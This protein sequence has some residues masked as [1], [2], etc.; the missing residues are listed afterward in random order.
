MQRLSLATSQ[1]QTDASSVPKQQLPWKNYPQF[2]LLSMVPYG[3]E[4]T[5]GQQG[6]AVPAVSPP[7]PL[8]IASLTCWV[9][10]RTVKALKDCSA[11]AK[12]LVC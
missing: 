9:A 11:I 2:L 3:M 12:P 7:S 1:Q 10:E 5:F 8:P 4:C 6:L